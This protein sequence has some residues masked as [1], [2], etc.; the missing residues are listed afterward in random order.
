MLI[1]FKKKFVKQYKK[2]PNKLKIKVDDTLLLFEKNPRDKQLNLH[3]LKWDKK[4]LYSINATWDIRLLFR[5]EWNFLLI[6]FI[7]L[8][9]H[10]NLYK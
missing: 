5:K 4:W 9:N 3:E 8:G 10:N 1:K 2:L 7:E 6:E